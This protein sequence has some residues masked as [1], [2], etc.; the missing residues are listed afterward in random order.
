MALEAL[1]A[2]KVWEVRK[3][4]LVGYKV[5]AQWAAVFGAPIVLEAP[6]VA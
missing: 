1:E 5:V 2:C 6:E 4:A 3:L